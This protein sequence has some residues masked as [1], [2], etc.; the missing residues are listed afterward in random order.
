MARFEVKYQADNYDEPAQYQVVDGKLSHVAARIFVP[1]FFGTLTD[2]NTANGRKIALN[3]ELG[4]LEMA[5][6]IA[7]K[8]EVAAEQGEMI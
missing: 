5:L 3:K 7:E 2:D 6:L 8:L 1:D 4:A